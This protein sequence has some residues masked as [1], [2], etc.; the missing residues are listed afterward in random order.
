M[1]RREVAS[2]FRAR[3]AEAMQRAGISQSLLARRI[4]VDRST[5]SQL[6]S[7]DSDRL[8]RADTVAG[9][10]GQLQV[11]L[12]WLLGL[13]QERR[14]GA[15][16]LHESLE[17]APSPD[18]PV[19]PGLEGWFE[20]AVG[21]KIR[22]VP[23]TLPDL[24]KTDEVLRHE[25]RDFAGLST[26]AA[27]AASQGELAYSRQVDTDTE[28]C[29]PL[30]DFQT[31]ARGEGLW[32]DLDSAARRRQIERLGGLSEELYPGLRLYLYDGLTH[33]AVPYT[34][35]GPQRVALYAGQ[36]YLVFN[37]TEHIHTFNRHFD[38][39]IRAAVV[40]P[41][42]VAGFFAELRGEIDNGS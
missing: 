37:T 35:F 25:Y 1:D 18:A 10:A 24:F 33:Y 23:T 41:T 2:Q 31:F 17:I 29:A 16:I 36:L 38:D 28:I 20:E 13:S 8:P 32:R 22:H 39:L 11:S 34:I 30:Q 14:L 12:D 19:N 26:D 5:L 3:L 21:Y 4:G 6:L 40:Q 7:G 42:E 9:L 15:E 27:I